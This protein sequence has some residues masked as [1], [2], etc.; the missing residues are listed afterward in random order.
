MLGSS[1]FYASNAISQIVYSRVRRTSPFPAHA[2]SQRTNSK[3]LSSNVSFE[4]AQCH[5]TTN[6]APL[7]ETPKVNRCGSSV[8]LHAKR[9]KNSVMMP[10]L[11][12]SSQPPFL[13]PSPTIRGADPTL[14]AFLYFLLFLLV[15][16]CH[17]ETCACW[18]IGGS[19]GGAC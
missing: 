2:L 10:S 12:E 15:D 16:C 14:P 13:S 11:A 5:G 19:G 18:V 6:P 8:M 7:R 9:R 1:A 3:S 17:P 4:P